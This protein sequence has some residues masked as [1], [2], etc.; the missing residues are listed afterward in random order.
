MSIETSATT[1]GY[2]T[3]Q[4]PS[5]EEIQ[6]QVQKLITKNPD[7]LKENVEVLR[8]SN[9]PQS[10]LT[11]SDLITLQDNMRYTKESTYLPGSMHVFLTKYVFSWIRKNKETIVNGP[12][13]YPFNI[14]KSIMKQMYRN[15]DYIK[16][17]GM[18]PKLTDISFRQRQ[19]AI[20]YIVKKMS[21][22]EKLEYHMDY[23]DA[24]KM[25]GDL[26]PQE[27]ERAIQETK[28]RKEEN[29]Q[30]FEAK[31]RS[32]SEEES[33]KTER[34]ASYVAVGALMVTTDKIEEFFK[35]NSDVTKSFMQ[36]VSASN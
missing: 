18:K 34:K 31:K 15:P 8:I 11:I 21:P 24:V 25:Y 13:S 6:Q 28:K 33:P 32:R 16:G 1:S 14:L 19:V 3:T 35:N 5:L 36:F 10:D 30:E 26:D 17:S 23:D 27:E 4:E 29:K 12:D 2:T 20:D 7:F 22:E 9:I